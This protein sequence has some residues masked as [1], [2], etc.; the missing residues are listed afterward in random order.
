MKFGV[1]YFDLFDPRFLDFGVPVAVRGSISFQI[2]DYQE[3]VRL[4]KLENFDLEDFQRQ[5]CGG[6][7]GEKRCDQHSRR[8]QCPGSAD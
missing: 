5:G 2:A 6:Q 3:F 4:H 1:P 7:D 8:A